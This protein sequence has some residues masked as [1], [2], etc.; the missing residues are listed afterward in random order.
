MAYK[1][2]SC[3]HIFESGE[4]ARWEE[5][6]PYGMGYATEVFCGCP[7][8]GGSFEET[9]ACKICNGDF[10]EKE[11]NGRCVCNDCVEEYSKNFD[12]C[13]KIADVEKREVEINSLLA[14]LLDATDIETILYDCLKAKKDIDCSVFV[15][16]D[17]DWFAE[18]L[19]EEVSK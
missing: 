7:C 2:L 11:L 14:S 6:H 13:Y 18:N 17:K 5:Q 19:A 1:C 9:K 15:N 10:L 8:C 12:V 3:G 4:E 16:E